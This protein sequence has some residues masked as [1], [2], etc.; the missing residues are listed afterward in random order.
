MPIEKAKDHVVL[1]HSSGAF[2]KILFYGATAIE[3]KL[4]DGTENLFLS[5]FVSR[6]RSR[7]NNQR[8]EARR[9]KSGPRR[10]S[11]GTPN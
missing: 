3:W 10:D 4:A 11:L 9:I 7:A 6:D 8:S 1:K 2:V 5:T